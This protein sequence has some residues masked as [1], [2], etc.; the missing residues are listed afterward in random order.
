MRV[1]DM[2][3]AARIIVTEDGHWLWRNVYGKARQH[4]SMV[5]YEKVLIVPKHLLWKHTHDGLLPPYGLKRVCAQRG[6]IHPECHRGRTSD[7]IGARLEYVPHPPVTYYPTL[8]SIPI[9]DRLLLQLV[10]AHFE[11]TIEQLRTQDRS[12][13][14]IEPRHIAAW[15]LLQHGCTVA[16]AAR[17]LLRNHSTIVAAIAHV[18]A[19]YATRATTLYGESLQLVDCAPDWAEAWK[20]RHSIR[21][22]LSA[23]QIHARAWAGICEYIEGALCGW[24][25]YR[26]NIAAYGQSILCHDSALSDGMRAL[27]EGLGLT[28]Q[29]WRL[30][31]QTG[32]R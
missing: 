30:A 1:E 21:R 2:P 24:R 16:R 14:L 28:A 20:A 3:C 9:S 23:H 11:C 10:A 29:A 31:I 25:S 32:R 22:W 18:D 26:T 15:L 27:L 13:S 12:A 8:A 19:A 4:E 6:C 5:T 7:Q 17:L